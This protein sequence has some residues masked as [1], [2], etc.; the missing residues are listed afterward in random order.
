MNAFMPHSVFP[1]IIDF[2]ASDHMTGQSNLFSSYIP[3][4]S[5]DKIKIAYGTFSSIS[6]KSLVHITLSLS[7]SF[8][9]HITSFAINFLSISRLTRD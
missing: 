1:W 9:L 3:Y 7:L 6:S 8:V 4:T 5:S 2:G